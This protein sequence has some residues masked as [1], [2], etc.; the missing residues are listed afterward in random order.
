MT[1]PN[2]HAHLSI[3]SELKR[4]QKAE[5][6]EKEKLEKSQNVVAATEKKPST[7]P[8]KINE[9]EVSPNEYF[10]LRSAAV[11]ELKRSPETD[12][13]P[14]KFHVSTSL[15]EFIEKY[16]NLTDGQTLDDV[17]LR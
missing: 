17:K 8:E 11:A 12:P 7:K 2:A 9:E 3:S 13:Y 5:Q 1:I 4:R 15:E 14:H 16:A 10:K 6:K